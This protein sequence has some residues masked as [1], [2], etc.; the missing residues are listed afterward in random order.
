[1]ANFDP[2]SIVSA[3]GGN[4]NTLLDFLTDDIPVSYSSVDSGGTSSTTATSGAPATLASTSVT[5][6]TDE[7]VL[8][9]A[10]MNTS[11]DAVNGRT[12]AFIDI[13]A[14]SS[15]V[16]TFTTYRAN[17]GGSDGN[18]A[19]HHVVDSISGSTTIAL[20]WYTTGS[21]TSYNAGYRLSVF[22]FKKRA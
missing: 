8:A 4:W 14:S 16:G 6:E 21:T 13:G 12:V 7:I 5:P 15:R 19:V 20:K 3:G 10:Y 22:R 18:I 17:T 11:T 9:V 1:M 2:S